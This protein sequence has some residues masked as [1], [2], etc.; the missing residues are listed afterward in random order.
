[1]STVKK[2]SYEITLECL[3]QKGWRVNRGRTG[4]RNNIVTRMWPKDISVDVALEFDSEHLTLKTLFTVKGFMCSVSA[5][6]PFIHALK[7]CAAQQGVTCTLGSAD[8]VHFM[9]VA[10]DPEFFERTP[11]EFN[12]IVDWYLEGGINLVSAC[13]TIFEECRKHHAYPP[14]NPQPLLPPHH[15]ASLCF[16]GFGA[17]SGSFNA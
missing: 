7:E 2:A 10:E 17:Q 6:Q 11:E 9:Q 14:G 8:E 4:A 1:M 16:V 15:L 13:I 3:V 12:E 5:A